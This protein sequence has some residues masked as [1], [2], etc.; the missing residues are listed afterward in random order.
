MADWKLD[1]A[2]R[3]LEEVV[4]RAERCGPQ[5][6]EAPDGI[7]VVL[8]EGDFERMVAD[9]GPRAPDLRRGGDEIASAGESMS[10]VEF[11]QRSPLAAAFRAGEITPGGWDRAC[12]IGR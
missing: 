7:A 10:F 3:R 8:S 9:A 2:R 6:V 1:D 5:R 11:M 12:R 4:R